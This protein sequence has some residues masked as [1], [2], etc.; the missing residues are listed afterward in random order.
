MSEERKKKMQETIDIMPTKELKNIA[1]K[2]FEKKRLNPKEGLYLFDTPYLEAVC[3][4]ADQV[5]KEK[6]GDVVTFATTYFVHP[7]NLCELSCPFCSFYAKPDWK[8]AWF[9]TPDQ[10][11][12]RIKQYLSFDLTEIHVVGG[13]WKEANLDYYEEL[14]GKIKELD[15]SLHIKALDPIE[16]DYLAKIHHISIEEVLTKMI[17]FGLGSLPGGG[18][19]VLD[20][21]IRKKIAPQKISSDRY[22]QIHEVAHSLGLRSNVTMLFGHVEEHEHLVT[23]LCRVREL[24]DKTGG[25]NMFVPLLYH[26]ENNSLGTRT[27]RLKPKDPIRVYA[28]SR[29]ML[30]NVDDLKVLWNYLGIESALKIL[31]CGGNDLAS[32]ALDEKIITMAG[33]IKVQMTKKAMCDLIKGV[34]RVPKHTHSGQPKGA[35]S[36]C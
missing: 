9:Y 31:N 14:F 32:T 2:V 28:V 6:V 13:L 22:L 10:I 17:S 34:D 15:S 27:A 18:A 33:G 19:E 35:K 12:E 24:Q 25:Y 26:I 30:D 16:Y 1:Q 8:S 23:H 11:I 21:S 29:L 5:R 36:I 4:L 3:L 7:T 20:E